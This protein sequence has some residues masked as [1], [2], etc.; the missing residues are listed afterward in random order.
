[1]YKHGERAEVHRF[2]REEELERIGRK[3]GC[4]CYNQ[5]QSGW[6]QN[7][8]FSA[9]QM[10]LLLFTGQCCSSTQSSSPLH[11]TMVFK[12]TILFSSSLDSGVLVHNPLLLFTGQW[13]FSTQSLT[14]GT[15]FQQVH[16][17]PQAHNRNATNCNSFTHIAMYVYMHTLRP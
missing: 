4:G 16:P 15:A 2:Q 5:S 10:P 7:H 17:S 13:C 14:T 12:Y 9:S 3:M 6:F 8:N 11:W 1:M